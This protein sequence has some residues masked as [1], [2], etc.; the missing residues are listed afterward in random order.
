MAVGVVQSGAVQHGRLV[1]GTGWPER[2]LRYRPSL[3]KTLLGPWLLLVPDY[4]AA[5]IS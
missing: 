3:H 2:Y 4:W 5:L 1:V